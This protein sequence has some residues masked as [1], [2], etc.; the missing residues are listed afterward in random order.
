ME[1]DFLLH[2]LQSRYQGDMDVA[3][4]NLKVYQMNPSGIGEHPEI[5]QA[6]DM[7]MDK[8]CTAK[9]KHDAVS[10]LLLPSQNTQ[11]TLVE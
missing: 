3:L 2:A 11:K 1:N 4:A 7:E 10:E 5:I 8:Y 6:M 9:E